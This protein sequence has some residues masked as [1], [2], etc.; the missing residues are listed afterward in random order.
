MTQAMSAELGDV[1][2]RAKEERL[3]LLRQLREVE[4]R[5]AAVRE[6]GRPPGERADV[7]V[8]RIEEAEARLAQR[9]AEMTRAEAG[10]TR[11]TDAAHRVE[12]SLAKLSSAFNEQLAV[13][14]PAVQEVGQI[15]QQLR[16][17]AHAA[18]E[19][20]RTSLEVL[21][22]PVNEELAR[23]E[24]TEATVASQIE[25]MRQRVEVVMQDA[26]RRMHMKMQAMIDQLREHG[27]AQVEAFA[28]ELQR[29]VELRVEDRIDRVN[30]QLDAHLRAVNHRLLAQQ[31]QIA[32]LLDERQERALAMLSDADGVLEQCA[33]QFDAAEE[34]VR[35]RL[36]EALALLASERS[37][38]IP[39][40]E[41]RVAVDDRLAAS[42]HEL[43]RRVGVV[44]RPSATNASARPDPDSSLHVG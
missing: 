37:G 4:D 5:L 10:M 23:L 19:Q 6:A 12:A 42:T 26:M 32:A 35:E 20:T 34:R 18:I 11:H 17:A 8:R 16:D 24:Q 38:V 25:S 15:K 14:R 27:R 1:I 2:D 21:R 39:P 3:R 44:A 30:E 9:L 41:T 13:V 33:E 7:L 43:A 40:Q 28:S 36:R 31:E 22:S 29:Q